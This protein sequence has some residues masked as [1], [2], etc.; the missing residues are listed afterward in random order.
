MAE[1]ERKPTKFMLMTG[2]V[3]KVAHRKMRCISGGAQHF[4]P[5]LQHFI[6]TPEN[7]NKSR[8]VHCPK[9]IQCSLPLIAAFCFIFDFLILLKVHFFEISNGRQSKIK[10]KL[11]IFK[12]KICDGISVHTIGKEKKL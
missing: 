8:F 5:S 1:R 4:F 3:Q 2:G 10:A 9:N 11:I 7:Q 12:K 6:S